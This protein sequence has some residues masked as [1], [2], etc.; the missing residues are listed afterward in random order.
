[1]HCSVWRTRYCVYPITFQHDNSL[2]NLATSPSLITTQCIRDL[3][4]DTESGRIV[5]ML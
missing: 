5:K 4:H 1:M 3:K 2:L